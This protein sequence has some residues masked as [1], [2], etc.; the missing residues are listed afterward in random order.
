[1]RGKW[2]SVNLGYRG[3]GRIWGVC[4]YGMIGPSGV[5]GKKNWRKWGLIIGPRL[6]PIKIDVAINESKS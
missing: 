6:I 3:Q 4:G 1:M 5:G 2:V